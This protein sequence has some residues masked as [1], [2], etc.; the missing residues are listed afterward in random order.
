MY[1]KAIKILNDFNFIYEISNGGNL[2]A[3][4]MDFMISSRLISKIQ[5][6]GYFVL[7]N[8]NRLVI[9]QATNL[10]I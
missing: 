9:S 1:K 8:K 3:E 4:P 5:K 2:I 10:K 7:S 6:A